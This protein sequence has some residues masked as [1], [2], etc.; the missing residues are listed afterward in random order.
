MCEFLVKDNIFCAKAKIK[1]SEYCM[2]HHLVFK[3]SIIEGKVKERLIRGE[4]SK[5]YI[6]CAGKKYRAKITPE[7]TITGRVISTGEEKPLTGIDRRFIEKNIYNCK[8]D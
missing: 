7:K 6:E 2:R 4:E 8:V 5:L 3:D 1:D